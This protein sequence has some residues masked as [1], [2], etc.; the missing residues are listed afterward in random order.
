MAELFFLAISELA[1]VSLLYFTEASVHRVLHP[2]LPFLPPMKPVFSFDLVFWMIQALAPLTAALPAGMIVAN[3]ISR[4]I[5]GIRRAENGIM[6]EGVPDYSWTDLN[7]SLLKAAAIAV[8]VSV[9]LAVI[10]MT[11]L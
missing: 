6:A 1:L 7:I 5:P 11:R 8:P 3:L 4:S 9:I 10:S 2:E